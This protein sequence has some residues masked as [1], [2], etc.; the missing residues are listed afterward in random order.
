MASN[1]GR[2]DRHVDRPFLRS[3][4]ERDLSR[5]FGEGAM[6][7]RDALHVL[8]LIH[9]LGVYWIGVV[10]ILGDRGGSDDREPPCQRH[11]N[12]A[13]A[14]QASSNVPLTAVWPRSRSRWT[15]RPP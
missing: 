10:D 1:R 6:L 2:I 7:N 15:R 4:V 14:R 13:A 12:E 3:A 9:R 11:D 5:Q 8:N